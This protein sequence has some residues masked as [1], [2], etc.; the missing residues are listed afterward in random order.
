VLRRWSPEAIELD[1]PAR[2]GPVE[3][4]WVVRS[5]DGRVLIE[6]EVLCLAAGWGAQALIP[7]LPLA[8]VRG[9]ASWS[10]AA[11]VAGGVAWGGYAVP[12]RT[13]ALFGAT[14]D[15][16]ETRTEAL[17]EDD[18]R[19]LETLAR[20]LP[21]LAARIPPETVRGR[22]AVRAVTPDRLPLCGALAPALFVLGG[23]GS[24]GFSTAPLL[25]EHLAAVIL[26]APSPLPRDFARG[27]EPSR[28][29]P[30]PGLPAA[31]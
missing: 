21:G 30:L 25:A 6:T 14:H 8:P 7:D 28:F 29:G 22:A 17:A 13:G 26:G 10:D 12:T 1:A 11:T 19:N 9:Q 16:G 24:R 15:R 31:F 4:G 2:I 20:A 23:L 3:G 18:A 5:V 27:L